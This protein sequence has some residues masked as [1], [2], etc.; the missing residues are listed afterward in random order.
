M[1]K[2]LVNWNS[3][4]DAYRFTCMG[5][6]IPDDRKS[7]GECWRIMTFGSYWSDRSLLDHDEKA[8]SRVID[9]DMKKIQL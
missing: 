5:S 6:P 9:H 7:L 8:E 2:S 3:Q 1:L 4:V